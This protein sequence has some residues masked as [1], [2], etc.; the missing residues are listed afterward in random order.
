MTEP[1]R[2]ADRVKRPRPGLLAMLHADFFV[3]GTYLREIRIARVGQQTLNRRHAARRIRHVDDGPG[4]VGSDLDGGVS[5][6]RRHAAAAARQTEA[7]KAQS[8][9]HLHP[10]LLPCHAY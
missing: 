6:R 9:P 1:S 8:P 10:L 4:V 2:F 7:A 3:I 5:T